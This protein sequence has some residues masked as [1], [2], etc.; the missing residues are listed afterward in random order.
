MMKRRTL[1]KLLSVTTMTMAVAIIGGTSANGSHCVERIASVGNSGE[2]GSGHGVRYGTNEAPLERFDNQG[3]LILGNDRVVVIREGRTIQNHG[4]IVPTNGQGEKTGTFASSR[5][6][7]KAYL[8]NCRRIYEELDAEGLGAQSMI[9]GW[10]GKIYLVLKVGKQAHIEQGIRERSADLDVNTVDI[11]D[12]LILQLRHTIARLQEDPCIPEDIRNDPVA[13]ANRIMVIAAFDPSADLDLLPEPAADLRIHVRNREAEPYFINV[14]FGSPSTGYTR[15]PVRF[16]EGEFVLSRSQPEWSGRMEIVDSVVRFADPYRGVPGRI[17]VYGRGSLQFGGE[18][19]KTI[20]GKVVVHGRNADNPY[21]GKIAVA[22]GT[23][24][25][26]R[27]GAVLKFEDSVLVGPSREPAVMSWT[28]VSNNGPYDQLGSDWF[29]EPLRRLHLTNYPDIGWLNPDDSRGDQWYTDGIFTYIKD[30]N[31]KF[32]RTHQVVVMNGIP[33]TPR[34][35]VDSNETFYVNTFGTHTLELVYLGVPDTM[36]LYAIKLDDDVMGYGKYFTDESSWSDTFQQS[37]FSRV[38]PLQ[39][40]GTEGH[41]EVYMR[42]QPVEPGAQP[43]YDELDPEG[44]AV[45]GSSGDF[46][47]PGTGEQGV[48]GGPGVPGGGSGS[49]Y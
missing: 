12:D 10:C 34:A 25:V 38:V 19:P 47:Q 45:P 21:T 18:T 44:W 23:S 40:L 35:E 36:A 13:L 5:G 1:R 48:P 24:L 46:I 39:T 32:V 31:G 22:E 16:E 11:D 15:I 28:Y 29:T 49:Q 9:Q 41:P 3:K 33:P 20:T 42:V 14:N 17:D 4:L 6:G 37:T 8:E 2:H 7:Q 30:V 26:V 43:W 27:E